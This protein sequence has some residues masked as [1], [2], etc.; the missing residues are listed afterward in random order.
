MRETSDDWLLGFRVHRGG[1]GDGGQEALSLLRNSCRRKHLK[2][3]G[4]R[5][6]AKRIL[7]LTDLGAADRGVTS[8]SDETKDPE[9]VVLG[10]VEIATMP[11]F[12]LGEPR[13]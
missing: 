8:D 5:A 9:I 13:W 7:G 10:R 12:V 4:K 2:N 1:G 6:A 11:H 3:G